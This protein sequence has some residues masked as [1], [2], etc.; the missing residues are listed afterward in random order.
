MKK[1]FFI[2][3]ALGLFQLGQGI[4]QEVKEHPELEKGADVCGG[5]VR[6]ERLY[7]RGTAG[8][9]L[10]GHMPA[11]AGI[12]GAVTAGCAV[13]FLH[14]LRTEG[15]TLQKTGFAF[16]V[17]GALS[18]LYERCRNGCV[19]DYL[20]FRMPGGKFGRLVYNLADIFSAAGAAMI[21]IGQQ[22]P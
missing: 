16:L 2:Q 22:K 17:G 12:S 14:L 11:V 8:G 5:Y 18:N 3:L 19:L 6:L 10:Q 13:Y 7:N 1:L 9:K 15:R 20:R 4:R 21:C